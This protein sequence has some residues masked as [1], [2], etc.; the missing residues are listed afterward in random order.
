M[1][2]LRAARRY[3]TALMAEVEGRREMDAVAADLSMIG[4]MLEGSR[5]LRRLLASPVITGQKK[6]QVF[7]ALLK[8]RVSDTTLMFVRLLI[9]KHRGDLLPEIVEQFSVLRDAK[10]GIVQAEVR[11]AVGVTVAQRDTLQKQLD[12]YT[13]KKVNL[14]IE[15]APELKGGLLVRIGDTVLDAS[16]RRQLELLRDRFVTGHAPE[17]AG[18]SGAGS[19]RFE[20]G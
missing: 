8:K 2:N 1:K 5:E 12:H 11:S 10:L 14:L 18:Q 3:A 16:V 19:S 17:K 6:M 7:D 9:S 20:K 13:G 4:S 15:V